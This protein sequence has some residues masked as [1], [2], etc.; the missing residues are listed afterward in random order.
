MAEDAWEL[1]VEK[2][3]HLLN[4]KYRDRHTNEV[5]IFFGLVHGEDDFYYGMM[6][7]STDGLL[8]LSCVGDI[9]GFDME[10]IDE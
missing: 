2:Y 7:V 1:L 10:L 5:Y 3:E 8:L 4:R 6:S 9:E